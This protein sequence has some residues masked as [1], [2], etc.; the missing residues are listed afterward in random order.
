MFYF[1]HKS[2]GVCS[3]VDGSVCLVSYMAGVPVQQA[4]SW[5]DKKNPG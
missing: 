1:F 4:L 2:P 3:I 5:E